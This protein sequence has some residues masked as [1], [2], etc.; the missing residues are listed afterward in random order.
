MDNVFLHKCSNIR[1]ERFKIEGTHFPT[2][3]LNII[4]LIFSRFCRRNASTISTL[5]K[6]NV[7]KGKN[8]VEMLRHLKFTSFSQ[9][10]CQVW[11]ESV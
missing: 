4:V 2:A 11:S 1:P 10:P 8:T 9:S 7:K 3:I 6:A 5:Q